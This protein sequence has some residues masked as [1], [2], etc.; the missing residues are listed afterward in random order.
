M[1]QRLTALGRR[2]EHAVFQVDR[3]LALNVAGMA[4]YEANFAADM[5]PNRM[6]RMHWLAVRAELA[7]SPM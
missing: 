3:R 5:N 7:H 2:N 6:G 1:L 4:R